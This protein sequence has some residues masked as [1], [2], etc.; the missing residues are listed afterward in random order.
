MGVSWYA[1]RSAYACAS[2]MHSSEVSL[3]AQQFLVSATIAPRHH[4]CK[5]LLT[6]SSHGQ[7]YKLPSPF[8][9]LCHAFY[10]GWG[11]GLAMFCS[12]AV[13][14]CPVLCLPQLQ[15]LPM[16]LARLRLSQARP[17]L[18]TFKQL[19]DS[20]KQ[21]LDLQAA[22]AALAPAAAAAAAAEAG[23][24]GA[25]ASGAAAGYSTPAGGAFSGAQQVRHWQVLHEAACAQA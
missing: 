14:V 24:A 16:L 21:L 4:A 18:S 11:H 2:F 23:S 9:T 25:A 3:E 20:I 1:T 22:I 6:G 17:Q 13:H 10:A 7:H 8:I 12:A 5:L 19:H 15:D